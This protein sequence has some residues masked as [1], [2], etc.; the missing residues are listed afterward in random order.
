MY[1][2][3]NVVQK[4]PIKDDTNTSDSSKRTQYAVIVL[5]K[6]YVYNVF[7]TELFFQNIWRFY[8]M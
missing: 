1:I 5:K 6:I 8:N 2:I 3:L 7:I 4:I